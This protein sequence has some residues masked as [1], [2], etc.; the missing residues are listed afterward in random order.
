[1]ATQRPRKILWE[2]RETL[3]ELMEDPLLYMLHKGFCCLDHH[4]LL[5]P[6][7]ELKILNETGYQ[8]SWL[9]YESRNERKVD[10]ERFMR[11][12]YAATGIGDHAMAVVSLVYTAM[13]VASFPPIEIHKHT[14]REL[15]RLHSNSWCS[16]SI[17]CFVQRLQRDGFRTG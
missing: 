15:K 12:V 17:D 16:R 9:L 14:K 4:A 8:L 10:M 7:D 2:D 5:F 1:M 3:G 6:M 11:N 13:C